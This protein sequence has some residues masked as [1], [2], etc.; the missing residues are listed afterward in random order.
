MSKIS[1]AAAAI[2]TAAI[3]IM[4][5][6]ISVY[7]LIISGDLDSEIISVI[8]ICGSLIGFISICAIIVKKHNQKTHS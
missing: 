8:R 7:L 5:F 1:L 2:I 3:L 4:V 6:I